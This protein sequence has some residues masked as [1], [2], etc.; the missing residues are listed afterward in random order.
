MPQIKIL[1]KADSKEIIVEQ[2]GSDYEEEYEDNE[3]TDPSHTNA[4]SNTYSM[5]HSYDL[6]NYSNVFFAT[7][8]INL[9]REKVVDI[10]SANSSPSHGFRQQMSPIKPRSNSDNGEELR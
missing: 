2:S 9:P 6:Y 7:E 4:R 10:Q 5:S 1:V 3:N 8:K